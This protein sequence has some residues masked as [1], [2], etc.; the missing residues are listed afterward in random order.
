MTVYQLR[1]ELWVAHP[2]P[3]VFDFFSRAQNLERI[4]PPCMRFRILTH[5]TVMKLGAT[6]AY[7]LR[8]P[9][10]SASLAALYN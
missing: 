9:G 2:L 10:D 6:I 5:P 1:R 3:Q 4:T 7:A 8:V